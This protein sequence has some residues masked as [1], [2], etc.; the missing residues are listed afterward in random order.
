MRIQ[1]LDGAGPLTSILFGLLVIAGILIALGVTLIL[2]FIIIAIVK[3]MIKS[4]R[5]PQ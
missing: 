2:L 1:F 3:G 4:L 5:G